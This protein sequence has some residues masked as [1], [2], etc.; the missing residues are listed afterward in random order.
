MNRRRF[1]Q[2]LGS[3]ILGTA[4][5]LKIPETLIPVPENLYVSSNPNY[6]YGFTGFMDDSNKI[7]GRILAEINLQVAMPRLSRTI[8]IEDC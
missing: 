8:Y 1:F 5:A 3:A 4:I 2:S 6:A 7:K